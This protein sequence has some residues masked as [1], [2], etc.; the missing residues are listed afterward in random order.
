MK[1]DDLIRPELA[2]LKPY[3]VYDFPHKVKMDANENPY[4]MPQNIREEIA[5]EIFRHSFNRYP[6]PVA[7]DLRKALA[8][9]FG[10]DPD[11][12]VIGNGSDELINYLISAFAGVDA[13]V[14]F[15]VPTFSIYGICSELWGA[16]VSAIPL[17]ENFDL[18]T[19]R[20]I[21]EMKSSDKSMVFIGYPNNPTGNCFSYQAIMDI[22]NCDANSITVIDEAYAEF[23]G[24][25]FIPLLNEHKNLVILR[26]FSKAFGLAGLRVGYMIAGKEIIDQILKVKMVFNIN[27]LSQKIALIL[28]KYKDQMS[29]LIQEII[30][31][32]ERLASML[33]R[34][35]WIKRYHSD[36]NFILFRTEYDSE[37]VF[38]KLL[39]KGILVRAFS[40][41]GLLENCLR[42]T[43]GK[44]EEDDLF[45]SA[46]ES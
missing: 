41:K 34:I 18:Q 15:P 13:K 36:A 30:K 1:I 17:D 37:K 2:N 8:D 9:E 11:L 39:S 25:T 38:D 19:K 14:I 32:R 46:L 27:S 7:T 22:I 20:I 10:T 29:N 23:S 28:L 43:I 3:K 44:P 45:I 40:D 42:V 24:K 33:D 4:E 5:E 6:D 31:E 12:I 21:S 16:K 26:T 35:N